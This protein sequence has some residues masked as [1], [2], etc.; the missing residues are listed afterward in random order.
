MPF[1]L[2]KRQIDG[3]LCFPAPSLTGLYQVAGSPVSKYELL[4]LIAREYGKATSIE[5]DETVN[6]D[7]RLSGDAFFQATGY[8]PPEWPELIGAMRERRCAF[9]Q[10]L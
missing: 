4:R 7:K 10:L 1:S 2:I 3:Y 9:T 5:P 6:D 8:V